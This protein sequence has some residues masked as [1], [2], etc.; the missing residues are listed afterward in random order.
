MKHIATDSYE[1][2][3]SEKAPNFRKG[4]ELNITLP[5]S[6]T[7]KTKKRRRTTVRLS[8]HNLETLGQKE[9]S[10]T[11]TN[12]TNGNLRSL[13][14]QIERKAK[15]WCLSEMKGKTTDLQLIDHY[16]FKTKR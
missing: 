10:N 8:P 5:E 2:Y 14:R 15:Q 7:R 12:F 4:K 9:F 16:T 3:I 13:N 11:L 6:L 1:K